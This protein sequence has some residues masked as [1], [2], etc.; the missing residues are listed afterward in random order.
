V[1]AHAAITGQADGDCGAEGRGKIGGRTGG[2]QRGDD[3]TRSGANRAGVEPARHGR[4]Q[5][6][7]G[8]RRVAAA[9]A[10]M[11][12]EHGNTMCRAQCPEAVA[13]VP[14][15]RTRDAEEHLANA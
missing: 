7:S 4:E 13:P 5:A 2:Q 15:L 9:D 10:G 3:I 14:T 1:R 8:Q 11:M 6:N 12:I